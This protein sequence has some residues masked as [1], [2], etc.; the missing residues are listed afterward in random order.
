MHSRFLLRPSHEVN[1]I[2][3]GV[4]GRAKRKYCMTVCYFVAMSNHL[5]LLLRP[6]DAQQLARFMNYVDANIAK[7]IGRVHGWKE[8]FW[9][10]R[11]KP[12]AFTDE[13]EAQVAGLRYLLAHG[14][15]EGMVRKP[16]DWP[17]ATGLDA[18][19][20]GKPVVGHWF[21]RTSEYY[22][23]RSG[24]TPGPWDFAQEESFVLAPIPCWDHLPPGEIRARVRAL[25]RGIEQ[26]T[27][28][29]FKASDRSPTG[30]QRVLKQ[31]PHD[32]PMKTKRSPGP[33][34]HAASLVA[35]IRYKEAWLDFRYR[36]SLAAE[37]MKRGDLALFP[38]GCFPPRGAFV[39]I[40]SQ[41]Q[42]RPG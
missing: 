14:C 27:R 35:W 23:R 2:I 42:A 40:G 30:A 17:G 7:E 19:L 25:I 24:E 28:D 26:E 33:I 12:I 39:A 36:Y 9:G 38:A 32:R 34:V 13:E 21:D 4:I 18:L 16:A 8:R 22:S 37:R 10:R 6:G 31:N 5:H 41:A 11:Y 3:C 15:K 29:R 1:T 20:T